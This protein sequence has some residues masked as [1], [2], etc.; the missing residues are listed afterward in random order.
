MAKIRLKDAIINKCGKENFDK[1]WSDKNDNSLLDA[2]SCSPTIKAYFKCPNGI[3]DDRLTT[4]G[5]AHAREY[6]CPKCSIIEQHL[7]QQH[8]LTS[9]RYG[10][11][12][13]V[14]RDNERSLRDGNSYWFCDCDCGTKHKSVMA[15]MLK[16][17][18]TKS[19]GCLKNENCGE[20]HH[21]WKGGITP[22]KMKIRNSTSYDEWRTAVYKRDDYTCQCCGKH[23]GKMNAHHIK[24]FA[25]NE[26][27]RL[28]VTNGI[29]LC[30]QCHAFKYEGSLHNIYNCRKDVTPKQLEDYI[31][32]KRKLLGIDEHFDIDEFIQ[33]NYY[34]SS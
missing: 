16:R 14:E 28:D 6:K 25:N 8:D 15:E 18:A 32:Y 26:L 29:T 31:N 17:G 23:G 33:N 12:V 4:L 1:I 11:L 3:H 21:N 7:K 13:A 2:P 22:L 34:K 5:N 24:S 19:C 9:N 10:K 20:K 27:L 30:E